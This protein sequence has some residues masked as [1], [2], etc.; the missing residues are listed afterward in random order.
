MYV[1]RLGILDGAIGFH[2]CLLL[3]AYEHQISIKVRELAT[4]D[5]PA[6]T[7]A[8]TSP[9]PPAARTA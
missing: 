1:V 4:C 8:T 2:F 7:P 3:A 9:P 6:A 5:D